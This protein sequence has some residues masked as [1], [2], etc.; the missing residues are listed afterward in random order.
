M[1][2]AIL[3]QGSHFLLIGMFSA[4]WTRHRTSGPSIR[5]VAIDGSRSPR[6]AFAD[7]HAKPSTDLNDVSCAAT[8]QLAQSHANSLWASLS[9]DVKQALELKYKTLDM[10]AREGIAPVEIVSRFGN[11]AVSVLEMLHWLLRADRSAD[12]SSVQW[13]YAKARIRLHS[14]HTAPQLHQS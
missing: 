5:A 8:L 2:V 7:I 9:A 12:I 6:G 14:S 13:N 3:A 4:P 11:S 1:S 10:L